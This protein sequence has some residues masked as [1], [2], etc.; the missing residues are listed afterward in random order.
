M[1]LVYKY[2]LVKFGALLHLLVIHCFLN[3]DWIFVALDAAK[4]LTQSY[5]F[6]YAEEIKCHILLI[7]EYALMKVRKWLHDVVQYHL[8]FP[9]YAGLLQ[10][11]I[12][13]YFSVS[14]TAKMILVP[15]ENAIIVIVKFKNNKHTKLNSTREMTVQLY[16]VMKRETLV[17]ICS[18]RL[19]KL[20]FLLTPNLYD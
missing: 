6:S 10:R 14:F 8:K 9:D 20:L 2:K 4:L 5:F 17:V 12:W 16:I 19:Y 13:M 7:S 18:P 15:K 3:K 1:L 11:A